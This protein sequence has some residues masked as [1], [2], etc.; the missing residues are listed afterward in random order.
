MRKL[1]AGM[2]ISVGAPAAGNIRNELAG[3]SYDEIR[4]FSLHPQQML[5]TNARNR[6]RIV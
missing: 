1:I 5:A 2:K 3:K 6:W 4:Y